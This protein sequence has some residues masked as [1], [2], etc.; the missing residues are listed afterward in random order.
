MI[1]RWANRSF[2]S[3]L[4][5]RASQK[6]RQFVA[7]STELPSRRAGGGFGHPERGSIT[8]NRGC[9]VHFMFVSCYRKPIAALLR[10]SDR[11]EYVV[12]S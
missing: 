11:G 10:E 9:A 4:Q 12:S 3:L 1:R 2:L 5:S 8:S 7:D 6:T